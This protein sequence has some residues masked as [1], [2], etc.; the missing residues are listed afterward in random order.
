MI[1]LLPQS[2]KRNVQLGEKRK[3]ISILGFIFILFFVCLALIL[4][5]IVIYIEGQAYAE[6]IILE[7]KKEEFE[8]SE[9]KYFSDKVKLANEDFIKVADFCEEQKTVTELLSKISEILP[10]GV[11][12]TSFDYNRTDSKVMISTFS[13]SSSD[14]FDFKNNLEKEDNFE[15]I[16]FPPSCWIKSEDIDCV[17]NFNLKKEAE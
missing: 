4:F 11:H 7:Q 2:E 6:K 10:K 1:N 13:K 17:V 16:H 8:N 14:L 15:E 12:L 5:S 9:I 3:I